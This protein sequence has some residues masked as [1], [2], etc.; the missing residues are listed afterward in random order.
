[1]PGSTC[2]LSLFKPTATPPPTATASGSAAPEEALPSTVIAAF[3]AFLVPRTF[4]EAELH[5]GWKPVRT[6]APRY[7]LTK[8][9]VGLLRTFKNTLPRL[10][11]QD[12]YAVGHAYA[13]EITQEP[14]SY[15]PFPR[16]GAVQHETI[17]AWTGDSWTFADGAI[18]FEFL[19]GE[20]VEGQG[21]RVTVI[22]QRGFTLDE[23]RE[24]VRTLNF[25]PGG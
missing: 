21:I 4:D 24:F 10:E 22:G 11:Q 2:E 5:L 17:G 12:Y 7:T 15:P 9:G 25:G 16:Q 6:D 3:G 23:V 18:A 8:P 1:L 19:S 13:I 20:T 14:D